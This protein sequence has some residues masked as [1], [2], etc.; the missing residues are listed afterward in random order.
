MHRHAGVSR[1]R[2]CRKTAERARTTTDDA[3]WCGP[4]PR[5]RFR[6]AV[7]VVG[8]PP[9]FV[10][11]AFARAWVP[12]GVFVGGARAMASPAVPSIPT[13]AIPT[14]APVDPP[15]DAAGPALASAPS[16][17][18]A[19]PEKQR[20]WPGEIAE[21]LLNGGYFRARIPS[22]PP[23]DKIVG[24]LAWSITASN[25]DVDVDLFYDD[26]IKMGQ[27]LKLGESVERALRRM[28]CPFP[29]QAH[30]IQG[31][32]YPAIFPVVRWLVKRVI[33]TREELGDRT[34]SFA[35]FYYEGPSEHRP[36]DGGARDGRIASAETVGEALRASYAPQRALR[37]A[38]GA[39]PIVDRRRSVRSVLMEY[40]HT[41]AGFVASFAGASDVARRKRN[42][43]GG[44]DVLGDDA[45]PSSSVSSLASKVRGMLTSDGE[46][47]SR[48]ENAELAELA[49]LAG[50]L[51][52]VGDDDGTLTGAIA[53]KIVGMRAGD[54]ADEAKKYASDDVAASGPAGK[55]LVVE[56]RIAAAEA[57][58]A[59]KEARLAEARRRAASAREAAERASAEL[60]DVVRHNERCVA[61]TEKL[62]AMVSAP[63]L[64]ETFARVSAKV[65]RLG[66]RK[67]AEKTFK[68]NCTR[69][70]AEMRARLDAMHAAGGA[71][72]AE[73]TAEMDEIAARYAEESARRDRLRAAV[74][75]KGRVT[76]LLRRKLDDIPTRPELMQYERRFEELYD[77]VQHRLEETRRCFDAYNVAAEMSTI[78]RKEISLLNSL[79]SQA[80]EAIAT[81][82]GRAALVASLREIRAGVRA[83]LERVDERVRAER[84]ATAALREKVAEARARRRTY[85]SAV[86]RF[87]EA[88]D[89]EEATRRRVREHRGEVT[90]SG[91]E[92]GGNASEERE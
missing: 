91:V 39:A 92:E 4:G 12:A 30:Q 46:S 3:S 28:R 36:L 74:A 50:D 2:L 89:R 23:F 29:L 38:R 75:K 83:N 69:E 84:A 14:F 85:L 16:S 45:E 6:P 59:A 8:I 53:A 67:A 49:A 5:R 13:A 32:D 47:A 76:Q 42:I 79:Q 11:A 31:L 78:V 52:A 82:E 55:L 17:F 61:E 40:G 43:G 22:L 56:R 44:K 90:A 73:E 15:S 77:A 68:A 71:L 9:T 37:R 20:D 35:A 7:L 72:T 80:A 48:E 64:A 21:L 10:R 88:C 86:K 87:Q 27:K 26:D 70:M 65:R 33:A 19:E 25:V 1:R 66:E 62:R 57:R 60:D 63:E 41:P 34:R 58:L 18:G 24:G 54:I 51:A 81:E